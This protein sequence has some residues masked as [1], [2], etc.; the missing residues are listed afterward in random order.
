MERK[1]SATF[2]P[3]IHQEMAVGDAQEKPASDL[4][5]LEWI[6]AQKSYLRKLDWMI[7][8]MISLLYF[9]EYLDR[10]NIAVSWNPKLAYI[11]WVRKD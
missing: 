6:A 3:A 1:T 9:F 11:V 10:G 7:L 4:D 8:P 2:E 5:G